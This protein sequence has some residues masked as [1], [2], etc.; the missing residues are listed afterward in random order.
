MCA[1]I[2]GTYIKR[3][4]SRTAAHQQNIFSIPDMRCIAKR[5]PSRKDRFKKT[6]FVI[7]F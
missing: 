5:A 6:D 1:Q 7:I 4:R 2:F 3:L